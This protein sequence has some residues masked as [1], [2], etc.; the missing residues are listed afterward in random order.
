MLC[1]KCYNIGMLTMMTI[2]NV[3]RVQYKGHK[4]YEMQLRCPHCN[5]ETSWIGFSPEE[6][7]KGKGQPLPDEPS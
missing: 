7:L 4:V 1:D 5:N 6:L 3:K 2:V